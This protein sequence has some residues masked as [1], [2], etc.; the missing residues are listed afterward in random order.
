MTR[1]RLFELIA[2]LGILALGL[3][4]GAGLGWVLTRIFG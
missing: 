3:L 1:S 2:L 4:L